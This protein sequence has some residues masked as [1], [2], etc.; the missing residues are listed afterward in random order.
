[1]HGSSRGAFVAS[2]QSL[3]AVLR[4]GA[5]AAVVGADL[6][7]VCATLDASV[8][9]RRAVSDPSRDSDA[10]AGLVTGLFGGKVLDATVQVVRTVV[11]QRWVT[12]RDLTDTLENLAVQAVLA[13]AE[14]AG[15]SDAVEDELFR[16]ERIVA[17]DPALRDVI[18]D[19]QGEVPAKVALVSRLLEGKVAPETL[20]LAR[21]AVL[22][23][24]GRR[25]G[26]VVVEYLDIAAARREQLTAVVTSA[27]ELDE[28]QKGRLTAALTAIYARPVHVNTVLDP[29]VIGGIR[30]QVGDEVVDGT[31]LR[32]LDSARRHMG[33]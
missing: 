15:R 9:L 32:R 31:V 17:A 3:D 4:D 12:D 1:M 5:D 27:I 28:T 18:T 30:V 33:A 8:A 11:A 7:G 10:R 20:T 2:E 25:F 22:A 21:Q 29:R 19:R 16:F 13:V 23:P 6:F 26:A 14:R 24:R